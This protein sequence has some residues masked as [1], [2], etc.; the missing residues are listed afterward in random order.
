MKKVLLALLPMYLF[1]TSCENHGDKFPQFGVKE[2]ALG[3][4]KGHD[5]RK[6]FFINEQNGFAAVTKDTI[7]KTTDG[8][9]T[10]TVTLTDKAATFECIQF[11]NDNIG[12]VV[13]RNNYIFK[14]TDGGRSWQK[15]KIDISEASLRDIKCLNQDTLFV[16][17]GSDPKIN[18]GYIIKSMDGGKTW[19]TTRTIN[20]THIC[21]INASTGF[22]SGYNGIIKTTDSGKTW[23]TISALSSEDILFID[24]NRG[25]F[26]DKRSL[27]N[28]VDGGRNWKLVKTIVNPHWIMGED[29]SKI[30]CLNTINNNDLI[31]TLNARLI[32]VNSDQKWFQYEFTRPYYQL[33]MIGPKTGIVYGFENLILIDF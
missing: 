1:I 23:D 2:T 10:F 26:S 31:F 32:K 13:D 7:L 3:T 4:I 16:A 15:I 33:Q 25:Y 9:K 17:A 21:F 30:E 8:W 5:V 6:A 14:T 29:F 12:F 27:Y 20:L 28:T 19:D 11:V 18:S 24:E 22:V